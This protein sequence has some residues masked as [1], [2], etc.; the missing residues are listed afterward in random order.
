LS[1]SLDQEWETKREDF[2]I[3]NS[4]VFHFIDQLKWS[5]LQSSS[6]SWDNED[7]VHVFTLISKNFSERIKV[8]TIE[9][10]VNVV[11][12]KWFNK[13]SKTAVFDLSD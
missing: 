9:N 3:L 11:F 6:Q 13:Q 1:Y 5:L 10:L 7:L 12:N 8:E 2:E 4:N